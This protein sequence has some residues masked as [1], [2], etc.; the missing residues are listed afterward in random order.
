MLLHVGL[1]CHA[2]PCNRHVLRWSVVCHTGN[3]MV[4]SSKRRMHTEMPECLSLCCYSCILISLLIRLWQ[5]FPSIGEL[6]MVTLCVNYKPQ[7]S[8]LSL[9]LPLVSYSACLYFEILLFCSLGSSHG[10]QLFTPTK[11][12][13]KMIL[14]CSRAVIPSLQTD[15]SKLW[16]HQM[17]LLH[18]WTTGGERS[19]AFIWDR[20]GRSHTYR[21]IR[22][23][24]AVVGPMGTTPCG[25]GRSCLSSLHN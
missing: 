7:R 1:S 17:S 18:E 23:C 10:A 5:K 2:W 21:A 14:S 19:T 24:D 15:D 22:T 8:Q 20:H 25:Y 4:A 11:Q 9:K 6:F 3:N 16:S 13:T 12:W